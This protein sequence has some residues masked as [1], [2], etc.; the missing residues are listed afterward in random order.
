MRWTLLALGL[1]LAASGARADVQQATVHLRAGRP[2]DA[3]KLLV[4]LVKKDPKNLK[5][6]QLLAVAL[7]RSGRR[8]QSQKIAK[9]VLELHPADPIATKVLAGPSPAALAAS[10]RSVALPAPVASPAAP[11]SPSA[12]ASLA[13]DL[14]APIGGK[15]PAPNNA[16][17]VGR[18]AYHSD[19]DF[20]CDGCGAHYR[21]SQEGSRCRHCKLKITSSMM[22][23]GGQSFSIPPSL[24]DPE[25]EKKLA[26]MP[27]EARPKPPPRPAIRATAPASSAPRADEPLGVPADLSRVRTF[28]DDHAWFQHEHTPSKRKALLESQPGLGDSYYQGEKLPRP[29]VGRSLLHVMA[30]DFNCKPDLIRIVLEQGTPVDIRDTEATTPLYYAVEKGR[31]DVIDLLLE[32]RANPNA[33]NKWGG[34]PVHRAGYNGSIPNLEKLVK[35][36]GDIMVKSTN[37]TTVLFEAVNAQ[38]KPMQDYLRKKGVK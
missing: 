16:H 7:M 38:N 1:H 6:L 18:Q 4:P 13:D 30:G 21:I 32:F 36:G 25:Y 19:N 29:F 20:S 9:R 34:T 33:R 26:S 3:A 27:T 23:G 31:A 2:D 22:P 15:I 11:A 28:G 35:A 5:A 17:L 14:S 12:A 24:P 37:G 10:P 8:E